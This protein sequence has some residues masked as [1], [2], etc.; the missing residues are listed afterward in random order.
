VAPTR[1]DR[2]QA[3]V[4][5]AYERIAGHGFEGLRTRDVA[6]E[7][8]INVAT[9]HYY[10]PTKE[11]LIRAVLGHAM[12]RFRSTLSADGTPAEQLR[13]HLRGIRQLLREEPELFVVM[14]EL[15]LRSTRDEAIAGIFGETSG[16]WHDRVRAL[17]ARAAE[18]GCLSPGL[19]P[20]EVAALIVATI[21]GVCMVPAGS[22]PERVDQ[23]FHQLER[24]L[25]LADMVQ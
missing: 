5:A 7:V 6:A 3:L 21:K 23:A 22:S 19:V 15:A 25:G 18:Q 16:V 14:G 20:D 17:V 24:W 10:F 9:L 13:Y 11:A 2:R 4:R 1:E 8:G 12:R